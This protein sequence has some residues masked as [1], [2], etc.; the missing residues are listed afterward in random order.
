MGTRT[1]ELPE[2]VVAAAEAVARMSNRSV[3]EVISTAVRDLSR[4]KLTNPS[5][6]VEIVEPINHSR[7]MK[8]IEDHRT[9]YAGK[10]VAIDGDRLL[11]V[12]DDG[13]QVYLSARRAGVKGP[14]VV[15]MEPIDAVPFGGW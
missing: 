1:V 10:W 4:T 9:E 7:E 6:P 12:G 14:M 2:E 5:P 15:H 8:W 3:E 13:H 11:A